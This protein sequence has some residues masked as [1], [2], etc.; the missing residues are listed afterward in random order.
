[1]RAIHLINRRD[2]T[3][4]QGLTRLHGTNYRSCCWAFSGE[5]ARSLIGAW[6]FLHPISKDEPSEFGGVIE[7]YEPA[8]RDGEVAIKDGYAFIFEAKQE[9]RGGLRRQT[10]YGLE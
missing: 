10:L 9:G 7:C 3:S 5:E 6:I 4:F 2:G 1:M 8:K